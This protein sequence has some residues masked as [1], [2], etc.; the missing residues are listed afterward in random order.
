MSGPALPGPLRR[1]GRSISSASLEFHG[2][3]GG[4]AVARGELDAHL[5]HAALV[6][7]LAGEADPVDAGPAVAPDVE[8]DSHGLR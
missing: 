4:L 3:D 6:A 2:I 7:G 1:A 8:V 5:G